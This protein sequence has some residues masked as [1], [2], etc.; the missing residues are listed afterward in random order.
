MDPSAEPIPVSW[1]VPGIMMEGKINMMFGPEKAGKSRFLRLVMGHMYA[2]TDL[3]GQPVRAPKRLL[4][5]AAEEQPEQVSSSLL[6]YYLAAGG[7]L[8]AIKWEDRVTI[9][10]A[11]G[12]RLDKADQR[13]W[14]REEIESGG[15]DALFL[16]PLRRVHAAR[17]N[18]NDEM[19]L[20]NNALREWTNSLGITLLV[21]HHTGKINEEESNMDRIAT[22][23]RGAGDVTSI[24]D[25]ATFITRRG[26]ANV[27]VRRAGRDTPRGPLVLRDTGEGQAWP[28]SAGQL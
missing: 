5:L 26:M 27:H 3:W 9:V 1:L 23:S 22:W 20:I 25:W 12:M 4:Y 13:A 24:L 7:K 21:I 14:L 16:D 10:R 17:E 8:D 19:A 18:N 11:A 15:Y 28:L 2:G 6:R